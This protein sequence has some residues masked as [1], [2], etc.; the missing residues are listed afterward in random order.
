MAVTVAKK[1]V[2]C[3]KLG[4]KMHT[5]RGCPGF[6]LVFVCADC[7]GPDTPPDD[8]DDEDGSCDPSQTPIV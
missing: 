3:G 4:G 5:A 2:I 8:A 6:Q 1:C 7:L